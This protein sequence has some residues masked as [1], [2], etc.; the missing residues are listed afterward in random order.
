MILGIDAS[1]IR[2]GGGLTHL[3]ELLG[4]ADPPAHGFSRVVVWSGRATLDLL[5]DWPW[6][7]KS[8]DARLD[9]SLPHR[10][11]W[12]RF[13]LPASARAAGCD[14]LLV[15]GGIH[16][17]AFRPVVAISQNLLP[18]EWRE[19]RR[20]GWS[21]MTLRLVA[22]RWLQSRSFRRADGLIFLS[23]Y[24]R[25]VV[26]RA[27]ITTRGRRVIVPHGV[28]ER[29]LRAPRAQL[30]IDAYSPDRPFRIMYV[31]IIDMYKHQW[32]VAEAVALL[33]GTRRDGVP[34][35]LD[36]VGPAYPPALDRLRQVLQRVDPAG[37]FVRYWGVVP[38]HELPARYAQADLCLFAST[39]ENMPSILLEGMASGLPMA[40]SRRGPMPEVLGDA[41]AYF[42]PEDPQE[43]ARA[44]GELIDSPE[45]RRE[46]ALA[47]FERARAY[48]WARCA[49]ETFG[50]LANVAV[51]G[52]V[53]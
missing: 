38:H 26:M 2:A 50:F 52:R 29:F 42:D 35:V 41:G 51:S 3:V 18:F 16:S 33:R 12:Q 36:L 17:G 25:D 15:P 21:M 4:H 28:E 40:C 9:H 46:K 22:L 7:V 43:I 6:L 5:G 19:V 20:Y 27:I 14:A 8:H 49:D 39:C 37:E 11:F 24:A 48:S 1:N 45:L 31:S 44:L 34:V 47:S 10:T 13:R 32:H 23:R 53:S 30:P